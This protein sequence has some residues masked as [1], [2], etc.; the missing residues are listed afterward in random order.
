[1]SD[2]A[3]ELFVRRSEFVDSMVAITIDLLELLKLLLALQKFTF[4]FYVVLS[5]VFG[6]AR[7][8]SGG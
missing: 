2:D 4:K 5:S 6:N 3:T 7:Y 8:F 1:M